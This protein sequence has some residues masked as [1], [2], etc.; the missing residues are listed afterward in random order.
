M[1][2]HGVVNRRNFMQRSAMLLGASTIAPTVFGQTTSLVRPEWQ[3]FKTTP[4][5]DSFIK[6]VKLM[7]ANTNANDPKSWSYWTNIHLKQCPHS[8]PYFFAWHRGYLYYF[9]RQLRTVSGD[10]KLVLPYWDY[11]TN[12]ALPAEFTNPNGA[13][14]LYVQRVNTNVRQA[15]SMAPFSSTLI[16]FP[17]GSANA[18]EPSFEDAPHNPVH[19]IIGGWMADLQSP[20][21]PIFWLHHANVDRLWVA[22]VN[23]GAGRKMPPLS[24]AYWSGSHT[25]T[26]SLTMPRSSTYSTRTTLAYS[27]QN[28]SFPTKLPL[29]QTTPELTPGLMRAN[30]HRVQ[31]TPENL[32]GAL[33]PVGAFRL[34]PPRQ[35]SEQTFAI[36]GALDVGLDDRSISVQLS[37]SSENTQALARIATGNAASLPGS[38]KLY[39]SVHLV[40]DD[41]EVTEGGK[42]GG[43]YYQVVLNI[44]DP[45]G[46]TNRPRAVL[47]GTLGAFKINGAAHH[48]HGE[49]VQ[50]RYRIERAAFSGAS[51]RGGTLSVS[52]MRV[53]GDQSPKGGVIGIGEV[54]LE[55]STEDNDA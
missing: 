10:T 54:R 35:T 43:Y 31:A 42:A 1:M 50:L 23:A 16:A 32:Q 46:I 26:S 6:A 47:I 28:E 38:A 45:D 30:V 19:D 7:K 11:Y 36:G 37:M 52:F 29:A 5:Y 40:L 48:H 25:Y 21:D 15:L 24:N 2:T 8:A 44:P 14:P 18:F 55:T 34:S 49:P 51:S 27:Y 22:W 20:T 33:P 12:P 39:R 4:R 17:R 9:E 41:V 3:S 13:N 53:D